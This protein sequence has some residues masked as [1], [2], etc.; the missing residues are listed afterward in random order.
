MI[1]RLDA[2][3]SVTRPLWGWIGQ[4][5]LVVMGTHLAADRLDDA[6]GQALSSLPIPWSSLDLPFSI[7]IWLAVGAELA[8]TLWSLWALARAVA[9]PVS[10]PREWVS[11][12]SLHNVM[13]P[14]FW[15]TVSLAGCWT[16][17][18]AIE[19]ALGGFTYASWCAWGGAAVVAWRLSLTGCWHLLRSPPV[20]RKRREG[21]LFLPLLLVVGG[22]ALRYGWPIWGW[23]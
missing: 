5:A 11:R 22:F 16:I 9:D 7:G 17:A 14:V 10:G 4:V 19:D 1:R 3:L 2:T 18:M 23:L 20:P 6:I 8:V 13:A 21:W 12:W 15:L